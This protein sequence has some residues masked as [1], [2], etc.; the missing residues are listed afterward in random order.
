AQLTMLAKTV[1]GN[2]EQ[3]RVAFVTGRLA[4]Q[5][6]DADAAR[7]A[8]EG[9]ATGLPQTNLNGA[10]PENVPVWYS[11]AEAD[12]ALHRDAAAATRLQQ[13]IGSGP[14]RTVY[15]IQFVRSL[16]FLGQISERKGDRAKASEYYR[17]FLQYWGDGDIDRDRVA[18][19]R[20]KTTS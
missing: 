1:P 3:R 11:L 19:A 7:R 14:L 15:P 9:V 13:V 17:K 2:I 4:L 10:N 16:Y 20:R 8:L 18:D 12:L 6:G 5:R